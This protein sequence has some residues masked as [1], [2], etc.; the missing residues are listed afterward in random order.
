M[1]KYIVLLV[2]LSACVNATPEQQLIQAYM[3]EHV[4]DP[5]SYESLSFQLIGSYSNEGLGLVS[6]DTTLRGELILHTFRTK[7]GA[8]ALMQKKVLFTYDPALQQVSAL[9]DSTAERWLNP[10]QIDEVIP[11]P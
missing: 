1:K 10:V 5:S 7:N 2:L 4:N 9:P 8:G 3:Q 6:G 11:T